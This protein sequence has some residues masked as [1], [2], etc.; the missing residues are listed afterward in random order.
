MLL[1]STNKNSF[2]LAVVAQGVTQMFMDTN[3]CI[4][5]KN[6]MTY[7]AV[8]TVLSVLIKNVKW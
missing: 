4:P 1:L 6:V 7:V 2:D 8:N 5:V 3:R